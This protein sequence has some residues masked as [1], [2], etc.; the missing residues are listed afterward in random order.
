MIKRIMSIALIL[1]SLSGA[2]WADGNSPK[3]PAKKTV[4]TMLDYKDELGMTDDQVKEVSDALKSFQVTINEQ[5]SALQTEEKE[6]KELLAANAPL[7][8]IKAK[9]RQIS[10]T[11][12]NLRYA[13]VLTSRRVSDALKPEQMKKWREIQAKVR[14]QAKAQAQAT[15]K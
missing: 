11:R 4:K 10:D 7:S 14:A 3:E 12:F 2:A 9:L 15:K 13:D 1:L 8:D 5:R 6:F